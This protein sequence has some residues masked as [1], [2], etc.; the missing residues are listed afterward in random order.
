M[1]FTYCASDRNDGTATDCRTQHSQLSAS[2]LLTHT[3]RRAGGGRGR[4][5]VRGRE[6]GGRER[7]GEREGERKRGREREEGRGGRERKRGK[8][9]EGERG[10]E[11]G[12]ER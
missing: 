10:R 4:E 11:R 3:Q 9:R 5:K 12:K 1:A 6:R 8:A 2:W 7:G